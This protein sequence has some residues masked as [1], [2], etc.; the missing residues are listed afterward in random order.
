MVFVREVGVIDN[1]SY[2]Q[3]TGLNNMQSS[4]ELRKLRKEG[5][6]EQ[7]GGG[8][9]T[10]YLPSELFETFLSTQAESLSTQMKGLLPQADGLLPQADELLPQVK[11][12]DLP[13]EL[14]RKL[15][16]MGQRSNNKQAVKDIIIALCAFQPF[17]ISELAVF[18]K[19]GERYIR[20][21]YVNELMA[22]GILEYTIPKMIS[23][24]NQ[25]YRTKNNNG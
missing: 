13:G 6:L 16:N 12:E 23:H 4:I 19:R 7:K 18:L 14:Q 8:K 10:Y 2:R 9:S 22:D 17:S 25:K 24:P 11:L 15:T 5:I 1:L 3:L 20:K 21:Q